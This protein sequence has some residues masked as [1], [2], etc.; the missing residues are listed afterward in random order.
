MLKNPFN[1]DWNGDN[2]LHLRAIG[3]WLV[4]KNSSSAPTRLVV[5]SFISVMREIKE[6]QMEHPLAVE[7][8][9]S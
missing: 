1:H 9:A 4:K 5:I 7:L 8:S 6:G 3:G 2:I